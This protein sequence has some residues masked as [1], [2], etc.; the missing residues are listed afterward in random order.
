[1]KTLIVITLLL[2]FNSYSQE[3]GK[4]RKG[5]VIYEYKQ[6][7]SFDLGNLE[8]KGNIIAPG[9]LSV[10][11]RRRKLFRRDLHHRE[12]FNPEVREDIR[13]LR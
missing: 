12:N 4:I 10:K 1:M 9:D 11:E 5:N 3:K 13:N 6:Y 7:E 2:S 8:I